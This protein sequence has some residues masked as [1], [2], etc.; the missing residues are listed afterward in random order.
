VVTGD[1]DDGVACRAALC[2]WLRRKA[3]ATLVPRLAELSREHRLTY[4]RVSLRQQKS[5][6]GSCSRRGTISLNV[7]LLFLAPAL[8]DHVLLHELCHTVEMNHSPRF[9]TLLGYHDPACK[10]HRKAMRQS[11]DSLPTWVEY[12]M[13][14]PVV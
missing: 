11:K 14:E 12:E 9:W 6:W 4:Q 13:G 5:R 1:P 2:R 7:N 10:A 3:Q 8:A